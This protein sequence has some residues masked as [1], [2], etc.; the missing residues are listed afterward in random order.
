[1]AFVVE[2]GTGLDNANSYV[3]LTFALAYFTDRGRA[4]EWDGTDTER[5]EWLIN[6][7][8]YADVRWGLKL[9]G[10]PLVD[11]QSLE[12]PRTGLIDRYGRKQEGVV[13]DWKRGICEYAVQAKNGRLTPAPTPSDTRRVQQRRVTVGPITTTTAYEAGSTNAQALAVFP[14]ADRLCGQ[15]A[16]GRR[17]TV[18][19]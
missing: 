10:K 8:D 11:T 5:E 15:F 3:D 16:S 18:R 4:T 7:T 13:E 9:K 2:D 12:F 14:M 6:A 19:N 17:R 1:M